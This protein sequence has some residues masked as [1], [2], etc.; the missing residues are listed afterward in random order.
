[1]KHL[2]QTRFKTV[3]LFFLCACYPSI[4]AS[5]PTTELAERGEYLAQAADCAGCHTA[6]NGSPYAGGRAIDTPFGVIYG[7]NITPDPNVGIGNYSADDFYVA[8]TQGE[9][10]DGSQLYPAMPYTAYHPIPREDSDSMYAY[11][12]NLKPVPIASPETDLSWP[13]SMRWTLNFWNFLYADQPLPASQNDSPQW[14]RGRYLVDVLG[15]C[16]Q[17]HTPRNF[18]GAVQLDQHLQG[19]V[20]AGFLA[21]AL[22]ADKLADR[23]WDAA[24]LRTYLREGI[25]AQGSAFSEMYLVYHHSTRHLMDDDLKAMDVYLLGEKPPQAKKAESA[26]FDRDDPGHRHYL[27]VC[28]GC[29]GIDGQGVPHVAIAMQGNSTLRLEDPRNLVKVIVEGIKAQTF[30]GF[31][32]MQAMPGYASILSTTDITELV[33]YLRSRWGGL[34]AP[35]QAKQVKQITTPD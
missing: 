31:E 34:N 5:N 14:Q 33:N 20:I 23:G 16:G 9:K 21:P 28:A 26:A 19:E 1:M 24:T 35:V 6:E 29:H 32:R 17:C 8:L 2:W 13:F 30:N 27:N 10:P 11:F 25:S 12:M 7:T 15:H 3:A 22:T 18:L 4:C